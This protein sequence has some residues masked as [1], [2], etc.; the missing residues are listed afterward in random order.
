MILAT[1]TRSPERRKSGS[2]DLPAHANS[3]QGSDLTIGDLEA[4]FAT[5]C[6][7]LRRL[8]ADGRDMDSIRRT[9]CWDYLYRLHTSLPQSYRS[10]DDL[11]ARYQKAQTAVAAN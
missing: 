3:D 9:I 5:Y 7:A 11:V 1:D 4:G 10:P 2:P 8:V 6:Q